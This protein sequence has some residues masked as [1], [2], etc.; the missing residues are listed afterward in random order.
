MFALLTV[1]FFAVT[2]GSFLDRALGVTTTAEVLSCNPPK[3]D[4]GTAW[5]P[6]FRVVATDGRTPLEGTMVF[7]ANQ[8]SQVAVR[9]GRVFAQLGPVATAPSD[10]LFFWSFLSLLALALMAFLR[11]SQVPWYMRRPIY[12]SELGTPDETMHARIGATEAPPTL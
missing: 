3:A 9:R 2:G 6:R 11:S 1:A 8:G 12:S 5:D 4:E 10:E 7:P